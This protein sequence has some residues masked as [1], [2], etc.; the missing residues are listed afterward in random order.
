MLGIRPAELDPARRNNSPARTVA[1]DDGAS[2]EGGQ[3]VAAERREPCHRRLR[4]RRP[5]SNVEV[6]DSERGVAAQ[7]GDD[8]VRRRAERLAGAVAS[9]GSAAAY[10]SKALDC[11]A[12]P[13]ARGAQ[14]VEELAQPSH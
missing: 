6:I 8:L 14:P 13:V 9:G 11:P 4:A 3:D 1:V 10:Q 5:P 7:L 12:V 2:A